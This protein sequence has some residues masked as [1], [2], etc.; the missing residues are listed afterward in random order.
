[1]LHKK[2]IQT[3]GMFDSRFRY[4]QDW[5]YWRRVSKAGFLF[6]SMPDKLTT[7]REVGN[8]TERIAKDAQLRAIR[9][10]EDKQIREMY[11]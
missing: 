2:V 4:G 5:H 6:H 9:D 1:M 10:S 7:R 3:V 11:R 8:L